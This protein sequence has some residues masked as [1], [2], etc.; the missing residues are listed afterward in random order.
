VIGDIRGRTGG[1]AE[2]GPEG[3]SQRYDDRE[4]GS[5]ALIPHPIAAEAEGEKE[6]SPFE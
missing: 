2:N 3:T 6:Y 1:L 5:T 4:Y